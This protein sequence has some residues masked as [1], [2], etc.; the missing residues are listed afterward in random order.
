MLEAEVN[1][2]SSLVGADREIANKI[3]ALTRRLTE[4]TTALQGLSER[5]NDC[6]GARAR[7]DALVAERE[8]GYVRVFE[9]VLGE[10]RVLRELYDPLKKRL[11]RSVGTLARLSFTVTR[12]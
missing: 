7:A 5:L 11:E 6:E 10:E 1:R 9:A 8:Q 4:E 3:A 2:L 12:V